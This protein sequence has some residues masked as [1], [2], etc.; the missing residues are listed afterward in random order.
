MDYQDFVLHLD[1][2]PGREGLVARVVRSPAGEAEAPFVNPVAR[3]E[4][5]ALWQVSFAAR[6]AQR[7]RAVRDLAREP[8][9]DLGPLA[10]E[11]SLE[12]L[13]VRL[14]E[15]LF[16]GPVRACWA[17]S[18]G[19]VAPDPRRGLRLKV[20]LGLDDPLVAA[21]AEVPWELLFSPEHGG[22]LALQRQTP[23]LRSLRLPL[24]PGGPPAARPLRVLVVSSQPAGMTNLALEREEERIADALGALLGVEPL[25]RR[26]PSVEELRETLLERDVHVL[27]F[28]GHGGFEPETGQGVLYFTGDGGAPLPVG[29]GLLASHLAGLPSLRLVFL[30]ACETACADPRAPFA[31]VASAL[32]RAGLPAVVAMQRPIRDDS[33]LELSRV[34]YRRLAA[35][36]PIDAALTEGRLA[37][38]RGRGALLEWG[39]PVLFLR[40]EDGR[41]F[42]E[43]REEA[44]V[45][46]VE[47]S[48]VALA[49]S[50]P[51]P[52]SRRRG[53]PALLAASLA[54]GGAGAAAYWIKQSAEDR[55]ENRTDDVQENPGPPNRDFA[56]TEVPGEPVQP[57]R[58]EEDSAAAEDRDEPEPPPRHVPSSYLITEDAPATIAAL[59]AQVGV[60]FHERAGHSFARFSVAPG[61]EATLEHDPIFGP[62]SISFPSARGTYH[63]EVR[64]LDFAAR[65]ASVSVRLVP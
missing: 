38:A 5:D 62:R 30:N 43:D 44:P 59:E 27:H 33:A 35:G 53:L 7:H 55:R 65:T 37:I 26:N 57:D 25:P 51:P 54:A 40:A 16:S 31:G 42:A 14:F 47:R 63:V 60:T 61:N 1:R 17:R 50:V 24:P 12:A 48:P 45:A 58:K 9:S 4:L 22:F 20:Q 32:L 49:R 46:A 52:R 3:A 41:L 19:A 34:V 64:S 8:V 29:A 28:M 10:A 21:L 13:G 56:T 15:A 36:D 11:L 18:F 39:T 23:V 2:A 6:Q